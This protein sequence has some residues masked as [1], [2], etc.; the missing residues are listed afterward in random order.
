VVDDAAR[1]RSVVREILE[2]SPGFEFAGGASSSAEAFDLVMGSKPDIILLDLDM[3][4]AQA[5]EATLLIRENAPDCKIVAWTNSAEPSV[6]TD[7]V[8]AGACG[9]LL[10]SASPDELLKNLDWAARGESVLSREITST[11]LT[12]LSR[13]YLDAS[14]RA[15]ELRNSYLGTVASLATALETKDD[16]TG[17]HA[18]RVRDYATILA[19]SYDPSLLEEESLV[20]GFL[21]HD[22]GKIGIP[23]QILLKPGPLSN[24]EWE[25]M[26]RHPEMG[27]RILGSIQFLQGQAM[28]V[29]LSHHE[30]WDGH[31][32]PH[33]LE[34]K[35]IPIGARLFG[36]VDAFD[37][38][39]QDRPYRTALPVGDALKEIVEHSGSQFDP[40]IVEVFMDVRG[41]IL[42]RMSEG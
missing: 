3:P 32:Y 21:L 29:V 20:F 42:A 27:W 4:G 15:E 38:M 11:V 7:M 8:A 34:E 14:E 6:V 26:R 9:Y 13:L 10:K 30:R 23:E 17:N 28:G 16:Q 25:I 5:V 18:R 12:E 40:A 24:D 22:V 19:E 39:T 41:D 1:P 2:S 35:E 33:R 37:A 31:G 36:V